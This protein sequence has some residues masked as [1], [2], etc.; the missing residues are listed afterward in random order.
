MGIKNGELL[1]RIAGVALDVFLTGDKNIVKQQNLKQTRVALIVMSAVNWRVIKP[2]VVRIAEAVDSA[3]R[4]TVQ[5]IQCGTFVPRRPGR[6]FKPRK[7]RL[8]PGGSTPF[9]P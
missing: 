7:T 2:H 5:T 3:E 9:R 4:G 8:R 6:P 1:R